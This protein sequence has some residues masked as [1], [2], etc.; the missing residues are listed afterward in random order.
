MLN[1]IFLIY[2][3]VCIHALL[4]EKELCIRS[5]LGKVA[6][7]FNL[8]AQSFLVRYGACART[9]FISSLKTSVLC[10]LTFFVQ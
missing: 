3:R 8:S 2:I 1:A 9:S 10:E 6:D 7:G 5:C 4:V